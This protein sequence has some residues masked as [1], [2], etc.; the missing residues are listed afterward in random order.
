MY[1]TSVHVVVRGSL[2]DKNNV[3]QI[4]IFYT[5]NKLQNLLKEE[6]INYTH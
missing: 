3:Y 1:I 5:S 4:G 2:I 6:D